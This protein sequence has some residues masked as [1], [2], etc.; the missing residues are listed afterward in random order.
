M[1][2]TELVL[3]GEAI[4]IPRIQLMVK[5]HKFEDDPTLLARPYQVSSDVPIEAFRVFTNAILGANPT[6][7]IENVTSLEL[8]CREFDFRELSA[9][10][11]RFVAE[12][13]SID[14]DARERVA[15]LE[16]SIRA[17]EAERAT[18]NAQL[19]DTA[20]GPAM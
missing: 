2:V 3:G 17:L 13:S 1:S 8:L 15:R 19:D 14:A 7:T 11:R 9:A 5:C 10:I 4:G 20:D 16:N 12:H 18:L 6:I